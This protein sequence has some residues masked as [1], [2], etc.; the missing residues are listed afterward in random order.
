MYV[1]LYRMTDKL[2]Y[3]SNTEFEKILKFVSLVFLIYNLG[4][5]RDTCI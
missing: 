4:F 5:E 1:T 3:L 2:I